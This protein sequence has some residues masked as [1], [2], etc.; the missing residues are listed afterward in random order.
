MPI[1]FRCPTCDRLLSTARRKAGTRVVC[2]RCED[3]VTVPD[4]DLADASTAAA[5]ESAGAV[6]AAPAAPVREARRPATLR[7]KVPAPKPGDS[8]PL[9]ERT[10]IE[11]LL[12]PVVAKPDG[13]AAAKPAPAPLPAAAIEEGITIGRG[14]AVV[15]AVLMV[16]LL[17]LAFAT[18]YLVGSK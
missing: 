1:R 12:G 18:G 15:L 5:D 14:A 3:E 6:P 8:G 13:A 9:F 17:A 7:P 16:V 11:R 4:A 2:P 10:D